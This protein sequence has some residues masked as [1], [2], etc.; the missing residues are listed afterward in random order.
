[1]KTEKM[2]RGG[3]V[4]EAPGLEVVYL[5]TESVLCASQ[6]ELSFDDWQEED[7]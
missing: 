2:N 3:Q 1:M 6:V 4:Y 5:A 7:L